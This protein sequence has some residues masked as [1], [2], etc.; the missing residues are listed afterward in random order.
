MM[1]IRSC[2]Q[3]AETLDH[4]RVR[5]SLTVLTTYEMILDSLVDLGFSSSSLSF[6]ELLSS[7]ADSR[8]DD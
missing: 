6:K 7:S 3:A 2:R 4:E 8:E 1:K 5:A